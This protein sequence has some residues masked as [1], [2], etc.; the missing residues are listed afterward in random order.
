VR[1]LEA[2]V[3]GVAVGATAL[4]GGRPDRRQQAPVPVSEFAEISQALEARQGI[5]VGSAQAPDAPSRFLIRFQPFAA[6]AGSAASSFEEHADGTI[7]L[8]YLAPTWPRWYD[9]SRAE[10]REGPREEPLTTARGRESFARLLAANTDSTTWRA[11]KAAFPPGRG[12]QPRWLQFREPT[13]DPCAVDRARLAALES[14][15]SKEPR[16]RVAKVFN[17]LARPVRQWQV[18]H[19][20][21][22]LSSAACR[23][24]RVAD[25]EALSSQ[26]QHLLPADVVPNSTWP[27]ARAGDY[28]FRDVV[29]PLDLL[30][31]GPPAWQ[32]MLPD[33][34]AAGGV[35]DGAK[36]FL[37]DRPV[38]SA[39]NH[40]VSWKELV[41]LATTQPGR[42]RRILA[43]SGH[44]TREDI[45]SRSI[46][47]ISST[48]EG[49]VTNSFLSGSDYTGD[50]ADA[51]AGYWLGEQQSQDWDGCSLLAAEHSLCDDWMVYL[52]PDPPYD[53]VLATDGDQIPG[54]DRGLGNLSGEL[55]GNLVTEVEQW[56]IPQGFRPEPGDR[57]QLVGRWI[58][59][60][61]HEDW[62]AEFHPVE[63]FVSSHVERGATVATVVVT[64][65]WPGGT[66]EL[67][68][69]PPA[70]PSA[71]HHLM[72]ACTT[73]PVSQ[74]LSVTETPEPSDAPNHVALR[75]RSTEPREA[76]RTGD[77]NQVTP[78]VARRL[79]AKF[80]LWWVADTG[81]TRP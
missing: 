33:G 32:T 60:C 5:D 14:Q 71:D 44:P 11:S 28:C 30:K 72:W 52:R 57:I 69:W 46:P 40:Y 77:W 61:G 64:G 12:P 67:D 17:H 59:D 10:D 25:W 16:S 21:R 2:V 42:A 75:I 39:G 70:R 54:T 45:K 41:A 79:A 26:P 73:A 15:R 3:L 74:E 18:S 43:W 49:V 66:L 35:N 6:E 1:S 65:D 7:Y 81:A 63:A 13:A 80:R 24:R 27:L 22:R 53:F 9:V 68:L 50:H 37:R 19:L 36:T 29:S 55:R 48:V 56:L 8:A 51:P 47:W 58:I 38:D 4:L 23:P 20:H 34:T 78:N 76:L 62:H 31:T